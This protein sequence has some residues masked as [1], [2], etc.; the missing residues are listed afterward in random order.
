M[1]GG[2]WQVSRDRDGKK[3]RDLSVNIGQA[4]GQPRQKTERRTVKDLL[5]LEM[6]AVVDLK[7]EEKDPFGLICIEA[8]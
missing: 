7:D 1:D 5:M 6:V 3:R 4:S 2:G 8:R